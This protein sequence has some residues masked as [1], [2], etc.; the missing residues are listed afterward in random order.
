VVEH[1]THNGKIEGLN[2]VDSYESERKWKVCWLLLIIIICKLFGQR[3]NK[4]VEHSTHYG[5][6]EGL[7]PVNSNE[8]ERKLKVG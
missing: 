4:V 5:N 7:N 1:T 3:V 6:F 2:P 8:S